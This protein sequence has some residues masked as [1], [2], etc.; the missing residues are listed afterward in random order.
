MGA[1]T[2][3][4]VALGLLALAAGVIARWRIR[5]VTRREDGPEV[6]DE[7][8]RRIEDEGRLETDERE[9]LDRDRIREEEDRFWSETWDEPDGPIW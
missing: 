7:A 8:V 5:R 3:V 1:G 2:L 6:D 4:L 9:P